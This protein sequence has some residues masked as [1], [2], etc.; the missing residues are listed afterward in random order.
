MKDITNAAQEAAYER[1]RREERNVIAGCLT[2]SRDRLGKLLSDPV[3]RNDVQTIES[4]IGLVEI[5]L[6]ECC[7]REIPNEMKERANG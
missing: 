3:F 7:K 5:L 4:M 2:A 1:G 6:T